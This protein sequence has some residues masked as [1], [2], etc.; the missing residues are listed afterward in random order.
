MKHLL[1][2]FLFTA[3]ISLSAGVTTNSAKENLAAIDPYLSS[4][5]DSALILSKAYLEKYEIERNGFGIVKGNL[6]L[7]YISNLLKDHGKT[8]LYYLEGIRQADLYDYDGIEVDKIWLRR[9][10]ANTFRQFEANQLATRYNLEAIEIAKNN[11][12]LSQEIDIKFNQA[13]VYQ[14]DEQFTESVQLFIGLLS[15]VTDNIYR[16]RITNQIGLVYMEMGNYEEAGAYFKQL[17]EIPYENRSF[18][19]KALHNLGEIAYE[20]GSIEK[21]IDNLR[22]AVNLFES[23][24]DVNNYNLFL[25][26]RNIGRHLHEISKDDEALEYLKRAEKIASYAEW[27]AGSFEIYKTI[28]NIYYDKGMNEI[29]SNYIDIYVSKTEDYLETQEEIQR[30]DKEYNFD[31]IAKRYFD[32]VK[33][34]EQI[35]SIL[36][37]SKTI[38]GS[39]LFLLLLTIGYNRYQ[40]VQLRKHLV[41]EL[42]ELKVIE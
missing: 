10:I 6:Y 17:L 2:V 1:Y 13:L 5:L 30:R 23:I 42:V 41:R 33:K 34:Q 20:E 18:T 11:N 19:A 38:S 28:S 37:Y 7:G 25:S 40:K 39:L 12:I 32:E 15:I 31:L 35:A 24:E 27:D 29:G 36:F 4:N 8:V 9:N 22:E 16:Y 26:Y 21:T 14:N 3:A